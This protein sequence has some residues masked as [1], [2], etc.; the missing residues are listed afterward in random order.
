MK[1]VVIILL[2]LVFL[3]NF[4]FGE[5][6][7]GGGRGYSQVLECD[8]SCTG[9]TTV[10]SYSALVAALANSSISKIYIPEDVEITFSIN[11]RITINRSVQI[12]GNRGHDGS[13]GGLIKFFACSTSTSDHYV[14]NV[15]SFNV[16]ISGLRI[17]GPSSSGT[18]CIH[19]GGIKQTNIS[20]NSMFRNLE[21]ENC[22]IYNWPY[23]AVALTGTND[24][25]TLNSNNSLVQYNY[26]H[27]NRR[28]G[29]GYGVTVDGD[30][31]KNLIQRNV[32]DFNRHSIAATGTSIEQGYSAQENIVLG[33]HTDHAFDMHGFYDRNEISHHCDT[34]G[35]CCD[36]IYKDCNFAG[37]S[38]QINSN[39]F[40]TK[41]SGEQDVVI[42]GIPY[43]SGLIFDNH[44]IWS[45]RTKNQGDHIYTSSIEQ[46]L[47]NN[48]VDCS[49]DYHISTNVNWCPFPPQICISLYGGETYRNYGD[50][51]CKVDVL[52][53][54][55]S[56]GHVSYDDE[57]FDSELSVTG[58]KFSEGFY[59]N[60]VISWGDDDGERVLSADTRIFIESGE[61]FSLM[62]F[63]V[64]AGDFDGDGK[65]DLLKTTGTK[66][67]VSW[68]GTSDW[69]NQGNY[70]PIVNQMAF[71]D[72]D[73]DG[74]TDLV[75][76]ESNLW[77]ISFGDIT[78]ISSPTAFAVHNDLLVY[79]IKDLG[80]G[81][82]NG[83][84]TTDIFLADG[85]NWYYSD[86]GTA[87]FQQINTSSI[88]LNELG[89]GYFNDDATTDVV[90]ND[91][92]QLKVSLG[93]STAWVNINE[94]IDYSIDHRGFIKI[95]N[96][97]KWSVKWGAESARPWRIYN[98]KKNKHLQ[99]FICADFDGDEEEDVMDRDYYTSREF[100]RNYS[101][102]VGDDGYGISPRGWYVGDF[103]GDG[104]D[105]I[106]RYQ[107][108]DDVE[109]FL[110][111]T[112]AEGFEA[113]QVWANADPGN[114][115]VGWY[116]GDFNGDGKD[117]IFRSVS[118][119]S[120]AQVFL[121]TGS[122][123]V[124]SGTSGNWTTAWYGTSSGFGW[125]IGDF[126]GDGKDDIMR[127]YDATGDQNAQVFL[128]TGLSFNYHSNW[129]TELPGDLPNSKKG[130]YIG[131]FNGDGMDDLL[132]YKKD[133]DGDEIVYDG[134]GAEVLLSNS[135]GFD[136]PIEWL[137]WEKGDTICKA[138]GDMYGTGPEGWYV[139]DFDGDGKDDL[140]R[141][142][143]TYDITWTNL[144]GTTTVETIVSNADVFLS[145]GSKFSKNDK[146]TG[147][148]V[149]PDLRWYIGDFDG[150]EGADLL[151]QKTGSPD[152]FVSHHSRFDSDGDEIID[153]L[154]NCPKKYNPYQK[155]SDSDGIGD[156]CEV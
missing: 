117:D 39:V 136:S 17:E 118:G 78:G 67:Y 32:F 58:N 116:V 70:I 112:D 127:D 109:V 84:G 124:L 99:N 77:K 23:A 88:L 50:I 33:S 10:S 132:R 144:D 102:S 44:S 13:K 100:Y 101:Y 81:D 93:G 145:N 51:D 142:C 2:S 151:R 61:T 148:G 82:F 138:N 149:G 54:V 104:K 4:L 113:F 36:S 121:S 114:Y 129:T 64:A 49:R 65:D 52:T 31:N 57:H 71:G 106:F 95:S 22:E 37:G 108:N 134:Y 141:D 120:G 85:T 46:K 19:T 38:I 7:I 69:D 42:R 146:W 1:R 87:A 79:E 72:F 40:L 155:D 83:D 16:I 30:S 98:I 119:Y 154:D 35:V 122:S 105:D 125:Y 21:I 80:F 66:W 139:A 137:D 76:K 3:P 5:D 62:D 115:P 43:Y 48:K 152:V 14:I 90:W 130:W 86:G 12:A 28:D 20:T 47:C 140:M 91:S 63:N 34:V 59:I 103:N 153:S 147:W 11:E 27:H 29:Y 26:I 56:C 94:G 156:E 24:N 123:F 53:G 9:Y 111:D 74:K 55:N 73:G 135:N 68:G 107:S 133:L 25:Q 143:P 15:T 45:D 97:D 89:F 128:S 110:S 41:E 6:V 150:R 18:Q 126:N 92:G 8:N 131:D 60:K 96:T 75:F